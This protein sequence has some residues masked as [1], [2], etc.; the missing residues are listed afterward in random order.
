MLTPI[1]LIRKQHRCCLLILLGLAPVTMSA[2]DSLLLRDY[3]VVKESDAWL[4]TPNAAALTRY[5][6]KNI[7]EAD[8]SLGYAGGRLTDFS[9]GDAATDVTAQVA[10]YYRLN[11]RTVFFGAISYD[12]W[13]GTGMTGSAFLPFTVT[14]TAVPQSATLRPFDIVEDS[15]TNAGRKHRDTYNLTGA[16]SYSVTNGLAIGL[17]LDYTAAN[18][19]KYK[20]L[21]HKNKLMDLT[22]SAGIYAPLLPWLSV[23][24]NYTYHRQTES[25]KFSINGKSDKVYQSLIDYGTFLGQVE[26]FGNE[27]Y[28]DKSREMP[29]FEDGHG[30]SFQLELRPLNGWTLFGSMTLGHATGYYGRQSPY[31]VTYTDHKRDFLETHVRLTHAPLMCMTRHHLDLRY[32]YEELQNKVNTYRAV[33]TD[34]EAASYEYYD[35]TETGDKRLRIITADYTL[36]LG[37]RATDELPRWAFTAGYHWQQR[38]QKSYLFPY[39]RLQQLKTHEVVASCTRN[40][41]LPNGVFSLTVNG[42][43]LKGSGEPYTDGTF[44]T[45]AAKQSLPATMEAFL[46]QDYHL[47]TAAQYAI[48]LQAKYAFIFPGTPLKTYLRTSLQHRKANERLN[49][50]CGRDRSSATIAVGCTF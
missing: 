1:T 34:K 10:S 17:R 45:P 3:T 35:P 46:Y 41:L 50:Y 47:L 33:L 48:G 40:F 4:T 28:T 20:D 32:R 5:Q 22:A 39:Y 8:L 43:F 16:F 26:Q 27:G 37:Q 14:A 36:Y 19:A 30:G 13:S 21:R 12:N 9:G 11:E 25:V 24:A 15:L 7:A 18:Y 49:D 2:Q 23:G 38:T 6:L 29:L 42:G 44:A 31:T